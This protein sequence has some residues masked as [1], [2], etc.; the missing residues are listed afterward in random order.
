MTR[1]RYAHRRR[2]EANRL[3]QQRATPWF[4]SDDDRRSPMEEV[5]MDRQLSDTDSP[6][7]GPVSSF[8][9]G[10]P[11]EPPVTTQAAP[12]VISIKVLLAITQALFSAGS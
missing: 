9:K 6:D 2:S 5:Q 4:D 11:A 12:A 7:R 3:S 1:E 10:Q 8:R